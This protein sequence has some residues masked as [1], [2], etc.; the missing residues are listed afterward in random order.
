MPACDWIRTDCLL[1]QVLIDAWEERM[2]AW[3]GESSDKHVAGALLLYLEC[4]LS[5]QMR[6]TLIRHVNET[7]RLQKISRPKLPFGGDLESAEADMIA[8]IRAIEPAGQRREFINRV[9]HAAL[10]E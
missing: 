10:N 8:R 4:S 9:C 2:L 3:K 1:P 5:R 6:S 7:A